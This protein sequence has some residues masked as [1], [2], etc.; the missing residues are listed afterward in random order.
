[1]NL[2]LQ[3]PIKV[4]ERMIIVNR[5][6]ANVVSIAEVPTRQRQVQKN[7]IESDDSTARLNFFK[8]TKILLLFSLNSRISLDVK[9]G[10]HRC[11][12][13]WYYAGRWG[14][15]KIQIERVSDKERMMN[16]GEGANK[17]KRGLYIHYCLW[18]AWFAGKAYTA[19]IGFLPKTTTDRNFFRFTFL[20]LSSVLR[21]IP[22]SMVIVVQVIYFQQFTSPAQ[23]KASRQ[24]WPAHIQSKANWVIP[25][26]FKE[27]ANV[28]QI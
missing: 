8:Q 11:S 26:V 24:W 2:R 15:F 7:T 4:G 18:L 17:T 16:L 1:M 28:V 3:T 23:A 21:W 6:A 19:S 20:G 22:D 5:V 25:T 13:L 10:V 12:V 14:Y 27:T 9:I